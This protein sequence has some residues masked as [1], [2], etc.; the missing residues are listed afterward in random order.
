MVIWILIQFDSLSNTLSKLLFP[1]I[2]LNFNVILGMSDYL[3]I[4]LLAEMTIFLSA[5]KSTQIID[6]K[7]FMELKL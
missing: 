3:T 2:G 1:A 7:T 5:F 4:F 6:D